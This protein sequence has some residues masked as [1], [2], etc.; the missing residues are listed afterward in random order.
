[1]LCLLNMQNRIIYSLLYC[2]SLFGY[3]CALV[4]NLLYK[5]ELEKAEVFLS[6]GDL[7]S[8]LTVLDDI[9][10]TYT[11]ASD[12]FYAKGLLYGQMSNYTAAIENANKAY[13][14]NANL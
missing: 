12:V 7:Q 10:T 1:M 8:A 11:E 4:G 9:T 5:S 14:L 6:S 2:L 3:V 13:E